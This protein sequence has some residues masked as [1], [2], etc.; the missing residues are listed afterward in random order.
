MVTL[1]DAY[2]AWR[3]EPFPRGG[4]DDVV[5]ELHADLALADSWVAESIIP[6]VERQR[7]VP[8]QVDV[9]QE[10]RVIRER[11]AALGDPDRAREYL[12]YAELLSDVYGAFLRE[13][14]SV[15]S[16]TIYV[17]LID[18]GVDVWRPVEATANVDGTFRLP[19]QAPDGETWRFA[20][21]TLVRCE[22]RKLA[23]GEALVA[24]DTVG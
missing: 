5:G 1:A 3:R 13:G 4:S 21:G 2:A 6:F 14:G 24:V 11:A 8:A 16:P 18:E 17:E 15:I 23:D 12:R 19:D 22:L 7:F 9:P 10:L 20:P